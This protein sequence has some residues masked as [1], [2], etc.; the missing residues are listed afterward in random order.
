M[1]KTK[2]ILLL[3]AFLVLALAF[4]NSRP[5]YTLLTGNNCVNCHLNPNGGGQRNGLGVYARNETSLIQNEFLLGLYKSVN[6]HNARADSKLLYGSDDRVQLAS[7]G[8]PSNSD[9]KIFVMSFTPYLTYIPFEWLKINASYNLV[10]LPEQLFGAGGSW[11]AARYQG[12]QTWSASAYI[13][14]ELSYPTLRIGY[15][16]PSIG[17]RYDDHTMFIKQVWTT[18]PQS[19]L[20]PDNS[21][22][23]A[24]IIYNHKNWIQ[25]TAGAYG[26]KTMS[27]INVVNSFGTPVPVVEP[28]SFAY[29]GKI[30]F[31]PRFLENKLNTYFGGSYFASKDYSI[32]SAFA[33]VGLT[34]LLTL[35]SEIALIKK[36][37]IRESNNLILE[38]NYQ[39]LDALI[40]FGRF[41]TSST[42]DYSVPDIAGS[43]N[44]TNYKTYSYVIG[45]NIYLLPNVELRPEYRILDRKKFQSYAAQWAVQFHL[46][47]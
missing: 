47:L 26:T 30:V 7:L 15:F 41:E 20:P 46:Y 40:L 25:I 17:T 5:E 1:T 24:E 32:T 13:Q 34:D 16:S 19:V 28:N 14:P 37:G 4:V 21:E 11:K 44:Y 45:A 27:A 36:A 3:V 9:P 10:Y 42:D 8:D 38:A 22:L 33:S 6:E 18:Y 12:Q 2:S 43:T 31:T 29:L 23:G 39:M 35:Q